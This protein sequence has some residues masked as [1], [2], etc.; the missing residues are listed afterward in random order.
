M[1][2]QT[3]LGT[4]AEIDTSNTLT[5]SLPISVPLKGNF[6]PKVSSNSM[7]SFHLVNSP[8]G[9]QNVARF[10]SK[11]IPNVYDKTGIASSDQLINKTGRRAEVGMYW[12]CVSVTTV[13]TSSEIKSVPIKAELAFELPDSTIGDDEV[14]NDC[15]TSMLSVMLGS[16]CTFQGTT[17]TFTPTNILKGITDIPNGL[18]AA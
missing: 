16:L 3:V 5:G 14:I 18:P 2:I 12:Q 11:I 4:T 15:L 6:A 7:N 10:T 1:S 8:F 9:T 17:A 13:G